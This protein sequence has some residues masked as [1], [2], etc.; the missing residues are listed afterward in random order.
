MAN[1]TMKTLTIGGVT[2]E[3]VD[4][5]ARADIAALSGGVS[6]GSGSNAIIVKVPVLQEGETDYTFEDRSAIQ[7]AINEISEAEKPVVVLDYNGSYLPANYFCNGTHHYFAAIATDKVVDESGELYLIYID[8]DTSATS[9]VVQYDIPVGGSGSDVT[10]TIDSELSTTSENP[11]QNKVV[12][13]KFEEIEQNI[14]NVEVDTTLTQSGMAADSKVVGD[15]I[16]ELTSSITQSETDVE[17]LKTLVG[18]TSVADQIAAATTD[19]YVQNDEPTD[20]PDGS[21]WVDL[22]EEGLPNET[23]KQT[24]NVYVVDAATTDV[25]TVDFSAYTIGDVVLVTSS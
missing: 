20:A 12:A 15:K 7:T 23:T 16:D 4:A 25:T 24:A 5:A 9:L 22:D 8:Y 18:D 6:S 14:N 3:I 1:K 17:E 19:I 2:Y 13:K 21:I 10:I 11:I